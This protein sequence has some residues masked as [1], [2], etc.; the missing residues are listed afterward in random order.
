MSIVYQNQVNAY[1]SFVIGKKGF[2]LNPHGQAGD[3]VKFTK[4]QEGDEVVKYLIGIGT[5]K[6]LDGEQA[7]VEMAKQEAPSRVVNKVPVV[8]VEKRS[9]NNNIAVGCAATLRNGKQ[10]T[11]TISVPENEFNENTPYFCGR[12]KNEKPED[13]KRVDGVWKHV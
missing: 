4:A 13:Y 11:A 1:Q 7:K 6:K 5:L 2:K 10:C 12:H 3:T 9:S 8:E